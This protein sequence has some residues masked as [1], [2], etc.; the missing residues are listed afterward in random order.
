M[1]SPHGGAKRE[2]W[3]SK[4]AFVLA[5]AGSAVG[6]GNIWRFPTT[7]G[8]NG[9]AAFVVIYLLCV[10]VVGLPVMLCELILGRR[11]K[12]NPVGAFEHVAPGSPWKAVGGVGVVTGLAIL[13][14]YSVVAGWTLGYVYKI[15]AGHFSGETDPEAV[16]GQFGDFVSSPLAVIVCTTLFMG[17][18]VTVVA[19][20]VRSGIERWTKILMPLLF[21]MLV[22]LVLRSVTLE[23]ASEGLRFYLEPDLSQITLSTVIAALGQAFFSLSLGMGAIITYGSYISKK[24]DLVSAGIMVLI[25]DT[26]VAL[27]AGFA[28]FPALFTVE[29]LEPTAGAGLIFVVLPNVFNQIPLGMLFGALF[30]GLLCIAAL[31]STVSLLEVVAAYLI[32]ERKWSRLKATTLTGLF[33]LVLAIPSALST[34]ASSTLS[35]LYRAEGGSKGFLDLMDLVFGNVLLVVGG[36]LIA[37]FVGWRMGLGEA[38][39]ELEE[40]RGRF[41]LFSLWAVLV[42][43]VCP[44]AL[45]A[46][47]AQFVITTIRS[48]G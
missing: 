27:M 43:Y 12:R 15:V 48:L 20:G 8:E 31:T 18:T 45:L 2:I 3:G 26:T 13:S 19:G 10:L 17:L 7:V 11:S 35:A 34:G 41:S 37:V 6:L 9:G 28:I 21:F 14:Y 16:A 47:L 24:D 22:L 5:A 33:C 36:M 23:G 46:L 40:G 1:A 25:A 4:F 44:L 29:G 30:F 38:R 39:K 32:D 42:K